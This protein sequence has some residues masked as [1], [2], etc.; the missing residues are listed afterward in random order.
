MTA[1]T[2][3]DPGHATE[4]FG[5]ACQRIIPWRPMAGAPE[6]D[7][8]AEPPFGAMAC[9]LPAGAASEPDCH[10]QDELMVILGGAGVAEIAGEQHPV[11]ADD[12]ILIERNQPHVIRNGGT[13]LLRWVSVYW[14][15]HEPVREA[16]R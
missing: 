10:D 6:A 14:P 7:Q 5:M 12:V 9:Y 16:D 8:A 2:V 11:A 15:L 3:L 13:G 4:E 1:R